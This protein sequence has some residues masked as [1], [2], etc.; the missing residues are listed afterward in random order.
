MKILH[1]VYIYRGHHRLPEKGWF[2]ACFMCYTITS[3]TIIF[4]T[5]EKMINDEKNIYKI[6]VYIC[7]ICRKKL[8]CD[9]KFTLQYNKRCKHYINVN[10]FTYP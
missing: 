1:N 9:E 2:Q 7:P 6:Y 4:D 5:L 8:N 3:R 10:F